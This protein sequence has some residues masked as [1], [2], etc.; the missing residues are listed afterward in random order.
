MA[1][2]PRAHT[3][4]TRPTE[5][6]DTR[7]T[8]QKAGCSVLQLGDADVDADVA[9]VTC[10]GTTPRTLRT[11][12]THAVGEHKDVPCGQVAVYEAVLA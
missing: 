11:Y 12:L 5:G 3:H 1:D 6:P 7:K 10:H 9:L 4:D 8:R 2:C